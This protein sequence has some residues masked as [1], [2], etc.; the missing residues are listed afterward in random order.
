VYDVGRGQSGWTLR[1]DGE[2]VSEEVDAFFDR[3]LS[4]FDSVTLLDVDCGDFTEEGDD[5][6][7]DFSVVKRFV[8]NDVTH[9]QIGTYF[10][11]VENGEINR[12]R[13]FNITRIDEPPARGIQN[14]HRFLSDRGVEDVPGVIP[15]LTRRP[16]PDDP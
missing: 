4:Y 1:I 12:H 8:E 14:V 16:R 3:A 9:L 13:F 10:I 11:S 2:P 6:G 5:Q 7:F 15:P